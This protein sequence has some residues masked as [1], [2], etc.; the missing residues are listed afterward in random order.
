MMK[1]RN[2][3]TIP[4]ETSGHIDRKSCKNKEDKFNFRVDFL[5]NCDGNR[6]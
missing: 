4:F 6:R 2:K 3:L 5:Y 1:K